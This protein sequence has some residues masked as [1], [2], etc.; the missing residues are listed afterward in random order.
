MNLKEYGA[1]LAGN[2]SEAWELARGCV[3][4]A[5]KR[6]KEYYDRRV[7]PPT[8]GVGDRVFLFKPADKTGP[9][10]KFAR[11]YH[12]PY[13]VLEMDTNTARIRPVDRPEDDAILVAVDRLRA[14][15]VEV[16]DVFWP[17]KKQ[18][19]KSKSGGGSQRQ[20]HC[21]PSNPTTPEVTQREETGQP[22][23]RG[24]S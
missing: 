9:A 7:Q 1:Q 6:Q 15:P 12:G 11:A 17:A 2:M 21:T 8:F 5:Q 23:T 10:R 13:R 20:K 24:W 18:Q 16:R 3:R 19:G 22:I 4:K 14:C